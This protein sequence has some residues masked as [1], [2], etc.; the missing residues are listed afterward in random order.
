MFAVKSGPVLPD[1]VVETADQTFGN[2]EARKG[3]QLPGW[4]RSAAKLL[5][6]GCD[7][8]DWTALAKKLGPC[9]ILLQNVS[10]D[11]WNALIHGVGRVN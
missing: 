7:G 11:K 3:A 5:N 10:W 1:S 8:Q 4:V 9:E 2:I 6:G